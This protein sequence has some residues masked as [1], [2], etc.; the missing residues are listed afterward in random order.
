MSVLTF[1]EGKKIIFWDFDGVIKE[2]IDI[3]SNAFIEIFQ[4]ISIETKNKIKTHHLDN[5]GMSRF[6]KIPLYLEWASSE[7]SVKS[8]EYYYN[9]FEKIVLDGVI[10]AE[11]VQGVNKFIQE[12]ATHYIFI[13]VSATP[14]NEIEYIL[15]ILRIR[16]FFKLI[17]GS[18]ITKSDAISQTL[19]SLNIS[20]RDSIMIGD[21]KADE[22]AANK[23]NVTFI[24]RK[25]QYNHEVFKDYNGFFI[26]NFLD[27][28]K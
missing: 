28:A 27:Y 7:I 4:N 19:K 18:P 2:S 5:G 25:H 21:A 6:E 10:N 17:Y 13:I 24:L 9:E 22:I 12:Q 16:K 3:K 23:N 1:L 8:L 26:N 11:W 14:Q 15:E 20:S